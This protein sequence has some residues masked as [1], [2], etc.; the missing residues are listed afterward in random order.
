MRIVVAVSAAML[1]FMAPNLAFADPSQA[2]LDQVSLLGRQLAAYDTNAAAA[3]D[4]GLALKPDK[5]KMGLYLGEAGSDGWTFFFGRLNAAHNAFL[6]SY[7]AKQNGDHFVAS[8]FTL[9]A[10]DSGDLASL[11]RAVVAAKADVEAASHPQAQY[12]IAAMVQPDN[13]I[14]VYVYPAQTS[15]DVLVY[16]ADWRYQYAAD[17]RTLV[18]R[19]QLHRTLL[20]SPIYANMAAIVHTDVLSNI[21]VETDVF[22][23]LLRGI[24]TYVSA[25][26]STFGIAS[27][28]SIKIISQIPK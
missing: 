14:F 15:N 12:D 18:E 11:A 7:E 2:T 20:Q 21:P 16:G 13:T 3:T 27:D 26:G 6:I 5:D 10:E 23:S 8:A 25:G 28:G 19:R 9:P 1:S 17:G 24:P 22:W 4:A